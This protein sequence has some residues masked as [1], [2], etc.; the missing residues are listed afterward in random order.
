MKPNVVSRR[1]EPTEICW[2]TKQQ[3]SF[4]GPMRKNLVA[5]LDALGLGELLGIG[6]CESL[7]GK[8]RSLLHST[9][10]IRYP[11]FVNGRNYTGHAPLILDTPILREFVD[12]ILAAELQR[13]GAAVVIPLGK[14]VSGVL[15]YL[16]G[17]G[18]L[19]RGHCLIGFP[20]PSGQN[21]HRRREFEERFDALKRRVTEHFDG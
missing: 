13:T 11:V 10:A 1:R 15:D 20:H 5:M 3:A 18:M 7:F 8:H 21:G 2:A 9:S 19:E 6:S 16:I 17:R 4:A 12:V 14:A